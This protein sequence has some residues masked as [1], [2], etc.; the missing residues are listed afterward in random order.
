MGNDYIIKT[1]ALI[2]AV[3]VMFCCFAMMLIATKS[4]HIKDPNF[5]NKLAILDRS[6]EKP[7]RTAMSIFYAFLF[8]A[9]CSGIFLA[10]FQNL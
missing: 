7:I 1:F 9:I 3:S 6:I 2:I 5:S 8:I 4:T 10:F